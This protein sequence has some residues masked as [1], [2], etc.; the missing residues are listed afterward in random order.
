M[1]LELK[2]SYHSLNKH[3]K[4]FCLLG[5]LSAKVMGMMGLNAVGRAARYKQSHKGNCFLGLREQCRKFKN[6][7]NAF[8]LHL[9]SEV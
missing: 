1:L 5:V 3:H 2:P 7:R 4:P 8:S 6:S 9:G